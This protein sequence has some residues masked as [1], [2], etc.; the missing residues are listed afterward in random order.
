MYIVFQHLDV[1]AIRVNVLMF[2]VAFYFIDFKIIISFLPANLSGFRSGPIQN[3]KYST[4][5][6]RSSMGLSKTQFTL[7]I[8][9][10]Y[11]LKGYYYDILGHGY[12]LC[13]LRDHVNIFCLCTFCFLVS[14]Q[15]RLRSKSFTS[16]QKRARSLIRTASGHVCDTCVL[17]Y[18]YQITRHLKRIQNRFYILFAFALQCALNHS[19]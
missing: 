18:F 16:G 14:R 15:H 3:R 13:F 10:T 11:D 2:S 17:F 5:S 4:L 8:F 9:H 19:F 7:C 6:I 1:K 12:Q